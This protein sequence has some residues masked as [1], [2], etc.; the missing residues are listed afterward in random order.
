MPTQTCRVEK[1]KSNFS[2][3][4]GL[5]RPKFRPGPLGVTAPNLPR[6]S[7]SP[8]HALSRARVTT[9]PRA[10]DHGSCLLAPPPSPPP[11]AATQDTS[12]RRHQAACSRR[13]PSRH[14]AASFRRYGCHQ[15]PPG[16]AAR[17][18]VHRRQDAPRP[19]PRRAASTRRQDTQLRWPGRQA[20]RSSLLHTVALM[21]KGPIAFSFYF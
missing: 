1:L 4:P 15:E 17:A 6:L 13:H 10:A 2:T 19:L 5:T 20:G 8:R 18:S 11:L 16:H 3:Q 21:K 12:S 14:P 7:I 9:L